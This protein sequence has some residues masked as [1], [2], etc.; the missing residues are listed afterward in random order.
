MFSELLILVISVFA[1]LVGIALIVLGAVLKSRRRMLLLSGICI[2]VVEG[3]LIANTVSNSIEFNPSV[4]DGSIVGQW[5]SASAHL[6]L[7]NGGSYHCSDLACSGLG[8]QGSWRRSSDFTIA[9]SPNAAG[10]ASL[11]LV[12]TKNHLALAAGTT[13]EDPDTW[14]PTIV[15][16]R[17][18]PLSASEVEG[19]G[20]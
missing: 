2:L 4:G 15:F 12:T 1:L 5:D 14:Q 7:D 9:F 13:D 20:S 6:T 8:S 3:G 17:A 10:Q 19:Y 11:R 18:T 16:K